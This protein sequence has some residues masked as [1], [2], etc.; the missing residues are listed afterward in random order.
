MGSSVSENRAST[1]FSIEASQIG[2]VA[3]CIQVGKNVCLE[4][5]GNA[6]ETDS[7]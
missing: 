3:G 4:D 2:K 5:G 7:N 6:F 1:V